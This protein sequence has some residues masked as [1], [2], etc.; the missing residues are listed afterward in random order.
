MRRVCDGLV[1]GKLCVR[2]GEESLGARSHPGR[3][4]RRIGGRGRRRHGPGRA[5]LGY[6]RVDPPAG[7]LV[8]RDGP[9]TDVGTRL[10]LRPDR[11]RLVA[12][13]DRSDRDGPSR[14][15]RSCCTRS[16]DRTRAMPRR[17]K[18]RSPTTLPRSTGDRALHGTSIAI[19]RGL[20]DDGVDAGVRQA[21]DRA[22]EALASR[23]AKIVDVELPH[24]RHAIAI[25]YLIATAEASSN[26]ARYDGV[27]YG[28][29]APLDA[30]DTLATMYERTRQA[31]FGPEVKRRIMLGTYVLSA[32][33]YDAYYLKGPAGAHVDPAGLRSRAGV[34]RCRRAPDEPDAGVPIRR[35]H[36]R[37][38]EDVSGGRVHRQRAAR[39]PARDQRA[40]RVRA[41]VCRS[42]CSSSADR[43]TRPRIFRIAHAY[44]RE[45]D[46]WKAMPPVSG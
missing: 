36:R 21:F 29:R 30:A 4:E 26:L 32:G 38:A 14:T 13:S 28:V 5:G 11:L 34:S 24:S 18:R 25:Y 17:R 8:R 15:P 20:L 19:P 9:Q 45:S 44:E 12:R 43:S 22:V 23:G 3:I 6:G 16:P 46:W 7:G 27:R 10:T 37:S 40:V 35:A 2:P 42:A 31:G 39:R 33:Y 41:T 1:D